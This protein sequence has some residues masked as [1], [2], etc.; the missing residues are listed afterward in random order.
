[1]KSLWLGFLF[2][3][4]VGF[5]GDNCAEKVAKVLSLEAPQGLSEAVRIKT[6]QSLGRPLT[7]DQ[8]KTLKQVMDETPLDSYLA[9][10]I[11]A[12]SRKLRKVGFTDSEIDR[13]RTQKVLVNSKITIPK[14]APVGVTEKSMALKD[15]DSV[16]L[17]EIKQNKKYNY[18]ASESGEIYLTEQ[19]L[20]FPKDQLAMISKSNGPGG[21]FLAR[22]M[23]EVGYDAKKRTVVFKPT[24]GFENNELASK[25]MTDKVAKL[26]PNTQA[27]VAAD[28]L[29]VPSS[30]L[31]KCLDI[32]SSQSNG[33]NFVLDRVIAEN[34][35]LTTAVLGSELAGANRLS[36]PEGRAVILGDMIG[37]T[38]STAAG[39]RV[40]KEL[41]L[42][43]VS[44]VTSMGVRTGMGLGMIEVQEQVHKQVLGKEN[45]Q[46]AEDLASF[47][48]A[49]FL[50]RLPVN[51]Y[52]D[53]FLVQKLPNL[54]FNSCQ[55]NP[56][57]S[58][59][60]SPRAI[61]LYER[62]GSAVLY[63]GLRD[64]FV[65]NKAAAASLMPVTPA[66][67]SEAN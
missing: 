4:H 19:K 42:R 9:T 55:R 37:S 11:E 66:A 6:A 47:N 56:A 67:S 31:I 2:L 45:Q 27:T 17:Q 34:M 7:V 62:Y 50:A 14:G 33:K 39:A 38:I 48:Q 57:L 25:A 46:L 20:G 12:Q 3:S 63:Y 5:A 44:F 26:A 28:A 41:S 53:K 10:E 51:H 1:M 30:R 43:D 59:M 60:V 29:K 21:S 65:E 18:V 64:H 32:V 40:G 52:F 24:H 16:A 58:V 36:T 13:L 35:V 23:G 61:R 8:Q 49:H 22:E 54:I 15:F